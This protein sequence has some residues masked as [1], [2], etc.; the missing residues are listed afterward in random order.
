MN[1]LRSLFLDSL[2]TRYDA[3]KRLA[4]AMPAMAKRSTCKDFRELIQRHFKETIGHMKKLEKVFECFAIDAKTTKCAIMISLLKECDRTADAYK[5]SLALEAALIACAQK[6]EHQEIASCGCLAEWAA[7]LGNKEATNLL[8]DILSE[9]KAADA[10]LTYLARC[11]A[12]NEAMGEHNATK[13]QRPGAI[14]KP[15]NRRSGV[16]PRTFNR[17][18][19]VLM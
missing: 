14:A 18:H 16:R 4:L 10:A 15:L 9:K 7:L 17:I 6:I 11:R 13:R 2:A 12:N 5:G 1:A 19:P 8:R 3:E